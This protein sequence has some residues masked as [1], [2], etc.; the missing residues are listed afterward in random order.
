MLGAGS[1]GAD[2]IQPGSISDWVVRHAPCLVLVV[3]MAPAAAALVERGVAQ[4]GT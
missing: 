3:K 4:Q 2:H 1:P